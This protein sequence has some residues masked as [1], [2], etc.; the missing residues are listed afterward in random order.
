[1]ADD[2]VQLQPNSTGNKVDCSVI[3]VGLNAVDRQRIILSDNTNS[4]GHAAVING[5]P[6]TEYG[7]V[8]RPIGTIT[9]TLSSAV[10]TA[11]ISG[12]PTV[13]FGTIA[14]SLNAGITQIGS[15]TA[16]LSGTSTVTFGVATVTFGTSTVTFGSI[17]TGTNVLGTVSANIINSPTVTFGSVTVGGTSTVTFGTV[18]TTLGAGA[19]QIGS[20]TATI[21]GSPTVTFGNVSI[22]GTSTV[23]FGIP[24]I[25]GYTGNFTAAAGN[26]VQMGILD[27]AARIQYVQ[28]DDQKR[29]LIAGGGTLGTP[30]GGYLSVQGAVTATISGTPTV[31]F[32]T[33]TVTF[34]VAAATI[35]AGTAQIGSVT[36]TLS[37]TS[38]VTF[39][40]AAATINAG[41]AQI[42]SITAIISGTVTIT[43][44][45]V[46]VASGTITANIG[47]TAT[48][49]NPPTLTSVTGATS[50][51]Q[52]AASNTS[53]RGLWIWNDSSTNMYVAFGSSAATTAGVFSTKIA[54]QA[55]YEMPS[56]IVTVTARAIWDTGVSGQVRV[57]ELT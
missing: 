14:A 38:T 55:Y 22:G 45:S 37:G 13:T 10:V 16:T 51:T 8:V 56:P 33:S 4:V 15:V 29:I 1:M 48:T 5:T 49:N 2:Y 40:I 31:T 35:N 57:T 25:Q 32:G 3:T 50:D 42:G 34:G 43:Q 21:S 36:A 30:S 7:L 54:P 46:T 6:S 39:G 20:V 19:N 9:A 17:P 53:R 28:G 23:T 11:S 52:L 24:L 18:S 47:N 26:P 41:T 12:T 27:S 44:G